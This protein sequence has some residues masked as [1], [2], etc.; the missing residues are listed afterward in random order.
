MNNS[1][2][3]A[4]FFNNPA[5]NVG[6]AGDWHSNTLGATTAIEK[7]AA[8]GIKTV[9]HLGDFGVW[10]GPAGDKYL[11]HLNKVLAKNDM[12]LFVTLGNHE[13]YTRVAKFLPV[14]GMDGCVSP[15]GLDRLVFFSRGFAWEWFGKKFMSV[16]GANSIDRKLRTVNK[17]WWAEEQI[18]D[19][20]VRNSVRNGKV[21][22]MF[23]HDAPHGFDVYDNVTSQLPLDVKLYAEQ[24]RKQLKRVTDV[25][26]PSILFHGHYH[27]YRNRVDVMRV[28]GQYDFY[29]TQ[30]ICLDLEFTAANTGILDLE[31]LDFKIL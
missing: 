25:V 23:C 8:A 31:T 21:D 5:S 13:S 26:K 22:V 19:E 2:N 16:G 4:E 18:S 30:H 17:D 20:D 15:D 3:I 1:F 7:F 29:Q 9:L 6:I 27:T 12:A 14:D 28:E 11:R 24:S 10:G